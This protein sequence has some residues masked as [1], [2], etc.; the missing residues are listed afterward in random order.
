MQANAHVVDGVDAFG[1]FTWTHG[2]FDDTTNGVKTASSGQHFRLDP[3][4]AF[5]V[6]V[7]LTS[8]E[9]DWGQLYLT[10]SYQ[11]KSRVYFEETPNTNLISQGAFGL[12][13]VKAGYRLPGGKI[14]LSAYLK[15]ALDQKYLID[16]GNTG[17]QFGLPTFVPGA[18]RFWGFDITARY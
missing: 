6:G 7:T 3:D 8:D 12:L 9:Y 5:A 1:N 16:A 13:N 11:W 4:F 10:P 18:P 14:E 17:E 2:R 15:N